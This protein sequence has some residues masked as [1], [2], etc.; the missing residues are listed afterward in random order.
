MFGVSKLDYFFCICLFV[1]GHLKTFSKFSFAFI[2]G[3]YLLNLV[4]F[5]KTNLVTHYKLMINS[6]VQHDAFPDLRADGPVAHNGKEHK[7]HT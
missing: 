1:I 3:Y 6:L 2:T 7:P 4:V 5:Y